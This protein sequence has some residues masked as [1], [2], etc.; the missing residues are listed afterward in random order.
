MEVSQYVLAGNTLNKP[1]K[2][3]DHVFEIIQECWKRDPAAR[4]S[5][6]E[7]TKRINLVFQDNEE[8]KGGRPASTINL[9]GETSYGPINNN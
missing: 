7:L 6:K 8:N 4:P 1:V 9:T 5:F 3:P 2:C